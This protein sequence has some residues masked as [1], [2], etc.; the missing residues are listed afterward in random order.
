MNLRIARQKSTESSIS[1][2]TQRLI[3]R[4]NKNETFDIVEITRSLGWEVEKAN[5][6]I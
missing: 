6:T 3:D 2:C 4:G 1:M 5:S